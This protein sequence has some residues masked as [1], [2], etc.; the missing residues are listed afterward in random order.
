[1]LLRGDY[2]WGVGPTVRVGVA[3]VVDEGTL[4]QGV[5]DLYVF[6]DVEAMATLSYCVQ[7]TSRDIEDGEDRKY[8][9]VRLEW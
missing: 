5:I 1:M 4:G 8:E 2:V 9:G 3:S 6:L 7:E